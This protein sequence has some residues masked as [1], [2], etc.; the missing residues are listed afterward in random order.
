MQRILALGLSMS[1]F[2]SLLQAQLPNRT[3]GEWQVYLNHSRTISS[4]VKNGVIYTIT[5]GGMFSYDP[6]SENIRTFSTIDGMSGISPTTIYHF[7]RTGQTFVGYADGQIDVFSDPNQFS[8]LTDIARN[9]SFVDKRINTF[10]AGGNRLYVGTNFGLVIYNLETGLPITDA[11]QIG[12]NTSRIPV[13]SIAIYQER[14]YLVLEGVGIYSAPVDFPN[15]KDPAA[16]EFEGGETGLPESEEIREIGAGVGSLFALTARTV[17]QKVDDNWSVFSRLD[18]TWDHLYVTEETVGAS[19]RDRV[20]I[21][22]EENINYTFFFTG[23]ARHV[24][25]EG[26]T[27][28]YVT[29]QFRGLLEFDEWALDYIIPPGPRSNDA[30]RLAV[31]AGEVYVAPKGYNQL[32]NPDQ[33]AT[34]IFHLNTQSGF[35]TILDTVNDRLSARCAA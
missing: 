34:G 3:Y 9:T 21:I 27:R 30:T 28:F 20:S 16:W 33:N 1:L 10:L 19:R 32:F 11:S 18:R 7:E 12:T 2:I 14:I 24:S 35:W 13:E 5:S 31:G 8:Y 22:N 6:D 17:Y 25:V 15:L 29:T 23:A 4:V 26:K